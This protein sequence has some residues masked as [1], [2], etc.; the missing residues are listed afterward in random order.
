V[1][2]AFIGQLTHQIA[3][4]PDLPTTGY[5]FLIFCR[6]DRREGLGEVQVF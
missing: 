3:V 2:V 5:S 1:Y 4:H 6:C